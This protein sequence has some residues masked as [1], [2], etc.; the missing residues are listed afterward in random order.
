L[1]RL[2]ASLLDYISLTRSDYCRFLQTYL[3]RAGLPRETWKEHYRSLAAQATDYVGRA[4]KRKTH[5]L[6]GYTGQS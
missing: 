5:K 2:A 3:A 1:V 4:Q 6:D